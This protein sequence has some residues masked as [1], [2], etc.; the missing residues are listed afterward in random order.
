MLP[1]S[2]LERIVLRL[3]WVAGIM[4][5][6]N[7]ESWPLPKSVRDEITGQIDAIGAA[8]GS[9]GYPITA[10]WYTQAH[11]FPHLVDYVKKNSR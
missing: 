5:A 2:E 7:P 1:Q 3:L 8:I 10:P 9:P 4:F 11:L 6:R